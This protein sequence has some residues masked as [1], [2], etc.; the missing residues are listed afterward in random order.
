MTK[1]LVDA[2]GALAKRKRATTGLLADES[3][4]RPCNLRAYA[5]VSTASVKILISRVLA[6]D[7][8]VALIPKPAVDVRAT[9]QSSQSRSLRLL[10]TMVKLSLGARATSRRSAW[11]SLLDKALLTEVSETTVFR[12]DEKCEEDMIYLLV[13]KKSSNKNIIWKLFKIVENEILVNNLTLIIMQVKSTKNHAGF[14]LYILECINK[15]DSFSDDKQAEYEL[16]IIRKNMPSLAAYF[17]G[18]IQ[19]YV[20]LDKDE[21]DPIPP[22]LLA[23]MSALHSVNFEI[24]EYLVKYSSSPNLVVGLSRHNAGVAIQNGLINCLKWVEAFYGFMGTWETKDLQIAC[25]NGHLE[26]IKWLAGKNM[27]ISWGSLLY[28][29][30]T[31]NQLEIAKYIHHLKPDLI[32][33]EYVT[34]CSISDSIVNIGQICCDQNNLEMLTWVCTTFAHH[35]K[36][37]VQRILDYANSISTDIEITKWLE[38]VN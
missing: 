17:G 20:E 31:S 9:T 33:S 28:T 24:P 13:D 18:V 25:Q 1:P 22:K 16:R 38:S 34:F 35:G 8:A 23:L 7:A 6:P 4:K 15:W 32:P 37:V 30:C 36:N 21:N 19:A 26:M 12:T 27:Y 14:Q 29:A 11:R 5:A 2:V 3:L 10:S